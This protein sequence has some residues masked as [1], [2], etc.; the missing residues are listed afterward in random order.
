MCV[1][2][3]WFPGLESTGEAGR[4]PPTYTLQRA[5]SL[6]EFLNWPSCDEDRALTVHCKQCKP[7]FSRQHQNSFM[8]CHGS[9]HSVLGHFQEIYAACT[10]FHSW[11]PLSQLI[12]RT[13]PPCDCSILR[14]SSECC[15]KRKG[16]EKGC[17][18]CHCIH[19]LTETFGTVFKSTYIC[20]Q[21]VFVVVG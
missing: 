21:L 13:R 3:K 7:Y 2:G 8:S 18:R 17:F 12:F 10:V 20:S 16:C 1:L 14:S 6:N 9:L 15:Y 19:N 11:S 5:C 4:V